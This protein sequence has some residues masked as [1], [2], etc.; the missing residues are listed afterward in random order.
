[1]KTLTI[2]PING[3]ANRLMALISAVRVATLT[4]YRLQVIWEKD[5]SCRAMLSD[6]FEADFDVISLEEFWKQN[7]AKKLTIVDAND[8]REKIPEF[9]DR[10]DLEIFRYDGLLILP[11]A[12]FI[13]E[14]IL[15][16]SHHFF[17]TEDDSNT[18]NSDRKRMA[19]LLSGEF[20]NFRPLPI[21]RELADAYS[22]PLRRG[23]GLHIRR[24][25]PHALTE[26]GLEREL[27][28]WSFPSVDYYMNLLPVIRDRTGLD[29]KIYLST[30]CKV[31]KSEVVTRLGEANV[32]TY[33]ARALDVSY[34]VA[35]IQDAVVDM[36]SLSKAPLIIRFNESTFSFFSAML[37]GCHQAIVYRDGQTLLKGP[38]EY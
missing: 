2:Y 24:T 19:G 29:G 37:G 8:A 21:L 14:S 36:I 25:Y 23:I 9:I 28:Q 17:F 4:G 32:L 26:E 31:T 20:S 3:L 35:G 22:E 38:L 5:Q 27:T 11:H 1:M 18:F 16:V 34:S 15:L 6:L 12:L 13:R 10:N 33:Q 30:N 7:Q